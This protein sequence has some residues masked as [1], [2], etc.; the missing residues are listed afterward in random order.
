MVK[1]AANGN[2]GVVR[3]LLDHGAEPNY[4]DKDDGSPLSIAQ[5]N[6]H[7]GV[8]AMLTRHESRT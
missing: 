7:T 8:I 2:F 4:T 1:P 3:L 5:L 6:D